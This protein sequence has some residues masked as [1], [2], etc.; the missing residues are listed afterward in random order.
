M[1][2]AAATARRGPSVYTARRGSE[3]GQHTYLYWLVQWR[4]AAGRHRTR[5]FPFTMAGFEAAMAFKDEDVRQ[6]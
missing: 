2:T 4:D 5:Y 3:R 6:G 1:K